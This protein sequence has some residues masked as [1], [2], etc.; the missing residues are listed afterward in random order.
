MVG[1]RNRPAT[2]ST[3]GKWIWMTEYGTEFEPVGADLR[4]MTVETDDGYMLKPKAG[5]GI[6]WDNFDGDCGSSPQ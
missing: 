2:P 1:A 3:N 6:D 5:P 4:R